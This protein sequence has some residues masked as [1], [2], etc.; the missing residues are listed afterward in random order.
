MGKKSTVVAFEI[1]SIEDP[2]CTNMRNF[3]LKELAKSKKTD[4]KHI[5]DTNRFK[6]KTLA[7]WRRYMRIRGCK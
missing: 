5:A 1:P 6:K 2:L 7:I 4:R 3:Q